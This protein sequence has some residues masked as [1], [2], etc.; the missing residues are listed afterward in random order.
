MPENNNA[1]D[2]DYVAKLARIRLS[3]EEKSRFSSQLADVLAYFDQL[4]QVDVSHIE[5]TAHAFPLY[6]V[7]QEDVPEPAFTPEQA[8]LNAPAQRAN[9][10][11]V[12][13]VIDE[14]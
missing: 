6:N 1:I 12:P 2:I 5:P 8:L 4:N 14:A 7:W 13:K 3:D 11:I 9:Q 10:L